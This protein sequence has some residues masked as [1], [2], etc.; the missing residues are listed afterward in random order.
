MISNI[1]FGIF[2]LTWVVTR[3]GISW[4]IIYSSWFESSQFL[5]FKWVPEEEYFF[6]KNVLIYYLI[7]FLSLQVLVHFWSYL[8]Y[9]ILYRIITEGNCARKDI[10][11]VHDDK[12]DSE[13]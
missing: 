10:V 4:Y 13:W 3:H 7:L 6:T 12:N 1:V 9:R 11:P 5:E 8:I 2:A